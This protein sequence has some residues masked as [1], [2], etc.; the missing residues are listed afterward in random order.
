MSVVRRLTQTLQLPPH[1]AGLALAQQLI[2][3]ENLLPVVHENRTWRTMLRFF[4]DIFP[5]VTSFGVFGSLW[6]FQS[7]RNGLVRTPDS[8]LPLYGM[9]R[10]LM[11]LRATWPYTNS[12]PAAS[13]TTTR[14]SM[15]CFL[16]WLASLPL[17]W[18]PVHKIFVRE[19]SGVTPTAAIAHD[20]GPIVKQPASIHGSNLAW[21]M[22]VSLMSC[23]SDM[24]TLLTNAPDFAF[25]AST[26]AAALWLQLFYLL[27]YVWFIS[28]LS[29]L[30]RTNI[31]ANSVSA[32]CD[33]T[34]L[35]P[36]FI[37]GNIRRGGYIAAIDGLCICPWNL[38]K[39]SNDFASCLSA[40][41]LFLSCIAGAMWYTYTAYTAYISGIL[42][43][44]EKFEFAGASDTVSIAAIRIYELSF[45][46]GLAGYRLWCMMC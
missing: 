30:R 5:V 33:L 42:I 35:L 7:R 28:A 8:S 45:L 23:I 14:D 17:S 6:C 11:L 41:T 40:H 27:S 4:H 24:V 37:A 19:D 38:L 15:S 25:W 39:S 18:F 16:F 12:L 2:T 1:D 20:I 36:R 44:V 32:G 21:A 46:T 31:S 22:V 29:L 13:G 9:G 26:P 10:V 34:V 3:N 43:N